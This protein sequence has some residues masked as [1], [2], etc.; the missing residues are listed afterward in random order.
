MSASSQARVGA[1]L[2]EAKA[3][4]M[5]KEA[6]HDCRLLGGV[7]ITLGALLIAWLITARVPGGRW[8][9]RLMLA[10]NG[11]MLVA[12]GVWYITASVF[13]ERAEPWA[14][15]VSF[16]V[17][18]AQF[19]LVGLAF[20]WL[21]FERTQIGAMMLIPAGLN[22]FVPAGAARLD[23]VPGEGPPSDELNDA[24]EPRVP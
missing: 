14:V 17:I 19:A 18:A 15:R 20:G 6:V 5:L 2:N 24:D 22:V 4:Q 21:W 16:Y 11:V 3:R 8:I 7:F 12:P 13:I 23:L 10:T 9:A 1:S